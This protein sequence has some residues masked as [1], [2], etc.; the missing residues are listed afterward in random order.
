MHYASDSSG[1]AQLAAEYS[2]RLAD[3]KAALKFHQDRQTRLFR[4]FPIVRLFAMLR[5]VLLWPLG[6]VV[7]AILVMAVLAT[8][9][10]E[11]LTLVLFAPVG[12]LAYG[13]YHG[14]RE[15]ER[16]VAARA[17]RMA[18]SRWAEMAARTVT[19]EAQVRDLEVEWQTEVYRLYS[20]WAGY[21][22]DWSQRR[23]AVLSRD[24]NKCLQ[25]GYPD[26]FK[27]RSRELHVHHRVPVSRGGTH[28]LDNLV[29]LCHICHRG[30]DSA[31][32]GV[33]KMRA[34]RRTQRY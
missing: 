10:N 5:Y 11:G 2:R 21:P 18:G 24:G 12:L 4:S 13:L 6:G 33:R 19:A 31:H 27:R 8:A 30:L 7:V 3:A 16:A 26:G 28:S 1:L 34:P 23:S 14:I 32:S 22:P 20:G 15:W 9:R 25:C 17:I 29:T